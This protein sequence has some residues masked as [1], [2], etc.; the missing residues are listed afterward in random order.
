MH[1]WQKNDSYEAILLTES[2][3]IKASTLDLSHWYWIS[4][5][6]DAS[7]KHISMEYHAQLGYIIYLFFAKN[8]ARIIKAIKKL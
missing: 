3:W 6:I 1:L 7:L 2:K 5:S 4:E 8:T